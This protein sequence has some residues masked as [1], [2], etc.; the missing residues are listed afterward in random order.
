MSVISDFLVKQVREKGWLYIGNIAFESAIAIMNPTT[1]DG[2][3]CLSPSAQLCFATSRMDTHNTYVIEQ[4]YLAQD[5][6]RTGVEQSIV[7]VSFERLQQFDILMHSKWFRETPEGDAFVAPKIIKPS[8]VESMVADEETGLYPGTD[9]FETISLKKESTIS[10][11]PKDTTVTDYVGVRVK[12]YQEFVKRQKMFCK[13]VN[14]MFGL[15][16]C[17]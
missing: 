14:E 13:L 6:A 15:S 10:P 16:D 8:E 3:V 17:I 11:Y 12:S 2:M 5:I 9:T 1:S 7:A 4:K